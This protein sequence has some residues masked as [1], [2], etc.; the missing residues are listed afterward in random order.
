M[1]LKPTTLQDELT[2]ELKNFQEIAR[3]LNPSPGEIPVLQGVDIY[4]ISMPLRSVIGGDH[5]IYID[6]KKRYDLDARIAEAVKDERK[7]VADNL[8]RMRDRAGIL[9]ADVSGHRMTDA[10]IGA[11]LHQS[12]LLGAYYELDMYGEITT[13]IFEH[14]NTRFYKTNSISKYFTMIYG[15]ISTQ[16]KFRFLSAG[17][18]PPAVF[19]REYG[20][21]MPI[22][23]E[24][25]V[26]F[27]PAGML[28]T[29]EDLDELRNPSL[30][31]YKKRYEVNEINLLAK[32][33]I[34]LLFT[35]G[36]SEHDGGRFFPETA[37]AL[38]A[39]HRDET[40]KEICDRLREG[41]IASAAAQD[42]ISV[43]VIKFTGD[44]EAEEG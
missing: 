2:A 3:Y 20:R 16:G 28:P 15:E 26:S 24:R 18:Q 41:L 17:H 21:F 25:M 33:D 6:F 42:D 14:I 37:Q 38:L 4:G 36:F 30:H 12:F 43:V 34:L 39:E 5:T 29:G 13:K 19:S 31:A 9:V 8:R 11:M 32:G 35:D 7:K 27:P 22:C 1:E 44:A 10:V 40:A 23:K